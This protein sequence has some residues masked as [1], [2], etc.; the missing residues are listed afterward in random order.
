MIEKNIHRVIK[1]LIN[2]RKAIGIIALGLLLPMLIL[3]FTMDS[4]PFD[5]LSNADDSAWLG[6]WGG[7]LGAIVSIGGLY[8]QTNKQIKHERQKQNNEIELQNE[9]I[10]RQE[11]ERK[12]D[13]EREKEQ[14][15]ME[16]RPFFSIEIKEIQPNNESYITD[17][18]ALKDPLAKFST[19]TNFGMVIHN[20]AE[21]PM[22]A[23]RIKMYPFDTENFNEEVV[24]INRI[25]K[26]SSVQIESHALACLYSHIPHKFLPQMK[27]LNEALPARIE[28]S[29]YTERYERIRKFYR[30]D[31]K[32]DKRVPNI[33]NKIESNMQIRYFQE[34][35]TIT[36]NKNPEEFNEKLR[37]DYSIDSFVE[38]EKFM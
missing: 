11:K 14:Y 18:F 6:F 12:E 22:M 33:V 23:V 4:T 25:D 15:Y 16:S 32:Y 7:Y 10:A 9:Q 1:W 28:V 30:I 20:F 17:L 2:N 29:L 5:S 21:K 24:K 31:S 8:W 19:T 36:E 13:I 38:S 34:G 27:R 37:D 3:N 35:K 26:N